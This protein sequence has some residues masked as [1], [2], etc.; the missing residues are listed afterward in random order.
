MDAAELTG[1]VLGR[2]RASRLLVRL[3]EGATRE[4]RVA[5]DL[6]EETMPPT[7]IDVR[8][9]LNAAGEVVAWETVS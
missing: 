8:V 3:P 4:L 5:P 2:W 1:T 6:D 9:R 7:G